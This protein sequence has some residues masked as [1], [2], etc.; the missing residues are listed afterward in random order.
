M[1]QSE[2]DKIEETMD[3]GNVA[4]WQS[5]ILIPINDFKFKCFIDKATKSN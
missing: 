3:E 4:R 2:K 5:N 1:E